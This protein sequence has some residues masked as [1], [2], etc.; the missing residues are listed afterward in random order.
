MTPEA[1]ILSPVH[2][3]VVWV[4]FLLKWGASGACVFLGIRLWRAT[5]ARW[6]LLLSVAFLLPIVSYVVQC[7][8][9]GMPP[10]PLGYVS[11]ER[12]MESSAE[13]TATFSRTV[14]VSLEWDITAPLVALALWWA[15]RIRRSNPEPGASANAG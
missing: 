14:M 9:V 15:Y 12:F 2:Y 13:P 7:G 6:W 5:T 8:L 11:A 10:L 1:I 4:A 3:P